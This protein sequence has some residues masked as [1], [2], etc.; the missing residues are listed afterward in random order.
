[1]VFFEKLVATP[2]SNEIYRKTREE[3]SHALL[4]SIK[5]NLETILNS[6]QGCAACAPSLGLKDFNDATA[7]SHSLCV[8]IIAD[9][10]S[11]IEQ[12][13]PRV[14][15]NRIDY[16]QSG[17]NQLALTFRLVCGVTLKSQLELTEFDL[18]LN[19]ASQQF[20]IS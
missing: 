13:E 8:A 4:Y 20:T 18:V 1:M 9:I 2:E 6:R 3:K 19:S 5:R 10:R 15:V 12:F 11:N 16:I 17:N 7:S 14:K